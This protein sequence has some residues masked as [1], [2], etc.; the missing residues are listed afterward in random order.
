[1][2]SK[3]RKIM[4][5]LINLLIPTIGGFLVWYINRDSITYYSNNVKK[6]FFTPPG[7]V[8]FIVWSILY[9]LMGIAA[10]RVYIK[11]EEK[12]NGAYFFY[13]VQLIMNFMWSFIFFTFRLY[14]V[15][16]IWLIILFVFVIITFVK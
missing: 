3:K 1:M 7:M 2:Q 12:N 15:A 5:L 8:F 14:G 9:V 13:L 6:P 11:N 16:F 10:Y 4:P